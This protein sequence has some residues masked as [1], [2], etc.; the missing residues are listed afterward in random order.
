MAGFVRK[1]SNGEVAIVDSATGEKR[2]L[3]KP[4][5]LGYQANGAQFAELSDADYDSIPT[6]E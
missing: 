2:P 3:H 5:W 4:E 1:T 6:A